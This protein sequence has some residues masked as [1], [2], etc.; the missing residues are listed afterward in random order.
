MP[1]SREDENLIGEAMKYQ[2]FVIN[3]EVIKGLEKIKSLGINI[4]ESLNWEEQ[5][6]KVKN[7]L[8]GGISSLSNLKDIL[9]QRSL[10]KC[11]KPSLK[12]I[13]ALV[14]LFGMLFPTPN[15][16]NCRDYK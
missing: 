15:Y 11:T 12:A 13:F 2:I 14:I 5:Y 7:K 1:K 3:N 4:D 8:K 6:R 10:N 16:P 9:P